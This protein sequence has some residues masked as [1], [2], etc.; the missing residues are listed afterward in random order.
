[1]KFRFSFPITYPE[2][3]VSINCEN[4]DPSL[5]H[6]IPV[7]EPPYGKETDEDF[8]AHVLSQDIWILRGFVDDVWQVDKTLF[9]LD[10]ITK[11]WGEYPCTVLK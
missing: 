8:W 9:S 1:M 6:E 7:I 3:D 11:T 10:Y 5:L 2:T 4:L